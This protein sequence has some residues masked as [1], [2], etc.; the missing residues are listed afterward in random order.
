[1]SSSGSS[2]EEGVPSDLSVVTEASA[3]EGSPVWTGNGLENRVAI[4][5]GAGSTPVPSSKT[6][7][8]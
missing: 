1:M 3:K 8:G 6:N 7:E 5:N 2:I 4:R